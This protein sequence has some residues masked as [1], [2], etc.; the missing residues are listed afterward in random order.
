M[1]GFTPGIHVFLTFSKTLRSKA[2]MAGL[3]NMPGH[4]ASLS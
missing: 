4:D 3:Y 2:W 1:P